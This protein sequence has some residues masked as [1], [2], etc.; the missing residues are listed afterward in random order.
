MVVFSPEDLNLIKSGPAERRR[1]LDMELCKLNRRYVKELLNYNRA[2][3]QRNKLLKELSFRSELMETLDLWDEQ[4]VAAGI[5]LMQSRAVFLEQLNEICVEKYA[6]LTGQ[7]E[8]L[9]LCYEPNITE[10][11]YAASL[12]RS[13]EF[14]L[15]QKATSVGPHRDDIAFYLRQGQGEEMDLRKFGSQGQQ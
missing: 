4:L 8:A 13:R 3:L 15:R 12:Q 10:E 2:L 14:D 11:R 5:A 9:R 6:S 7:K 1:F